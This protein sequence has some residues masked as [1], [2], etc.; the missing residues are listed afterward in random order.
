M[1]N[2]LPLD[3]TSQTQSTA[4]MNDRLTSFW[5]TREQGQIIGHDGLRL[6]WCAFTKPEHKRAIIVVNGRTEC[7]VKYQ[8]VFF[9]LFEQGYDVYSHDHRG[10]GHSQRLVV[11]SDIGHVV[12][13]EHYVDDLES[14]VEQIVDQ[15][16][17][18][19]RLLLGHSMGG[20]I[21]L[22][23]AARNPC[24]IDALALS[25]PML[26]I[27][28][29]AILQKAIS[30]VCHFLS[31]FQHPAGFA[32]N[33]VPYS[34]KPF[35]NNI[36]THCEARYQWM[37]KLYDEDDTL[38]VGGASARWVWKSLDACQ[39][40]M[41]TGKYIKIP[42]L[43]MQA[44]RDKIVRN[45]SMFCFYRAR[46]MENLPIQFEIIANASH[47]LLFEKDKIRNQT[48]GFLFDFFDK[49]R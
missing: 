36:L 15:K 8:E 21:S 30:P 24:A 5:N 6:N 34:S 13:F 16:K 29:S 2:I 7:V 9:D 23:Y 14:F 4:G 17:H 47:E 28:V 20:T 25:A 27:E 44:A 18:L 48:L 32:P 31:F 22:L 37:R 3:L 45:E 1:P 46:E 26:G 42:I 19:H 43:L 12:E 35:K 10:Q 49:Q 39:R 33:Q 41:E 38:K 11:G 40:A